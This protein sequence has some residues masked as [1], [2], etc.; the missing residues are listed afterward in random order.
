[1]LSFSL[2]AE[3]SLSISNNLLAVA[4]KADD[5]QVAISCEMSTLSQ[6]AEMPNNCIDLYFPFREINEMA[7]SAYAT[8]LT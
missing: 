2:H 4:N 5:Y 7:T 8:L 3:M 6:I 1:M